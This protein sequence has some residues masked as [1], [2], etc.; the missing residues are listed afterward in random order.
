MMIN[1][2]TTATFAARRWT[3]VLHVACLRRMSCSTRSNRPLRQAMKKEVCWMVIW[4]CHVATISLLNIADIVVSL[5]VKD[6]SIRAAFIHMRTSKITAY[7][8][9]SLFENDSRPSEPAGTKRLFPAVFDVTSPNGHRKYCPHICMLLRSGDKL[10]VKGSSYS[11]LPACTTTPHSKLTQPHQHA[12][13]FYRN[14][15]SWSHT[16]HCHDKY[17]LAVIDTQQNF[18]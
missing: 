17:G 13:T 4:I 2:A 16:R 6:D 3:K 5:D 7:I 12:T 15:S 18:W 9:A 11:S 8:T 1:H 14:S 10:S